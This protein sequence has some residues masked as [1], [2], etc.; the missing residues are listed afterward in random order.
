MLRLKSM[1]KLII[2]TVCE[3]TI[4]EKSYDEIRNQAKKV[5]LD[6][7][8]KVP[9]VQEL[10]LKDVEAE[11]DGDP[12]AK[13]RQE[14]IFSYPGLYAIFVYRYAH[15]L[16]N[17]DVPFIPRIMTEHAHNITGIDI[18][19][20]AT[21]GE[22]FF[23]D[24]GTGIVIGETADE[25]VATEA[26]TEEAPVEEVAQEETTQETLAEEADA[27][28]NEEVSKS[29]YTNTTTTKTTRPAS[30]FSSIRIKSCTPWTT[31]RVAKA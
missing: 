3:E 5:T 13:S 20:G 14:V 23:I 28:N 29:E 19:P 10:L 27:E 4:K 24:H 21:I 9:A 12:A 11:F 22:Y 16:Y 1:Y 26:V 18:N 25:V 8:E 31:Y 30:L 15:V 2:E 7:I 6:F 17:L